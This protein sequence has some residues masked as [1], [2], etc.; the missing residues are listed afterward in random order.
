[1]LSFLI[2]GD[3]S[4]EVIY[5]ERA[6][7]ITKTREGILPTFLAAFLREIAVYAQNRRETIL[8]SERLKSLNPSQMTGPRGETRK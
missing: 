6:V 1:M 2:K 5:L 4:P 8:F 7:E 3:I